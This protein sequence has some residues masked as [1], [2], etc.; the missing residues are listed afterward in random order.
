MANVTHTLLALYQD[1][2]GST[3]VEYALLA[4]VVAIAAV[5]GLFAFGSSAAGLWEYVA[6]TVIGALH[7]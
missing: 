7:S 4:S 3:A 2:R 6:T 1:E 5:V